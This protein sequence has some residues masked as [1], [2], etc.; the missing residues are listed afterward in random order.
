M[1]PIFRDNV[2]KKTSVSIF[3]C[4]PFVQCIRSLSQFKNYLYFLTSSVTLSVLCII[5]A[6]CF[7]PF[8]RPSSGNTIHKK[9]FTKQYCLCKFSSSQIIIF[10]GVHT[11]VL[12]AVV[13]DDGL[14]ERPKRVAVIIHNEDIVVLDGGK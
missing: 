8:Y 4:T 10:R 6:T 2:P 7:G 14:Y 13:P 12:C 9:T 11:Y 1:R 5:T 3:Q